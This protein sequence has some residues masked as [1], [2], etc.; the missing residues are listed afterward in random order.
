MTDRGL[1]RLRCVSRGAD[2]CLGKKLPGLEQSLRKLMNA[3]SGEVIYQQN[4]CIP[5]K[6]VG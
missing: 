6:A 5:V 2:S 1:P 3:F 4:R